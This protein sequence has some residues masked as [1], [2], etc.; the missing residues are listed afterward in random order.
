M[1]KDKGIVM[2][3]WVERLYPLEYNGKTYEEEDCDNL[4]SSFYHGHAALRY[5]TAV[6]VSDGIW[7][8]P[9]G[10]SVDES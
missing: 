2:K 1:K 3:K 9:D 5:D 7:V 6:Y 4:F 10:T 8:Y